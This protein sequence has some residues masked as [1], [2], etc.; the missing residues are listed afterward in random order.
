MIL[1]QAIAWIFD[2]A[3]WVTTA[4][5]T[6]IPDALGAHLAL[7]AWS[8]LFAAIIAL[9][10]GLYIGHSGRGR[11]FAIVAS[12]VARALPTLGLLSILLLAIP[13]VAGIPSGYLPDIIVFALLAIPPILAGAYAGLEAVDPQT[14]DAARAVGMTELQ[15]LFKV[16]IPLGAALIV[17]GLRS[18]TLQIIATVT[19]A[20]LFLQTSLGT[21]I[22]DGLAQ[23][24]YVKMAAGAILVAALALIIDGILAL[25]QRFVSPRGVSRDETKQKRTTARGRLAA[26]TPGTPLE[27]GN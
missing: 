25:V 2:P 7:S 20:S 11:T 10:L 27:E 5:G 17:G 18:G 3:H 1:L 16:E 4:E 14:V 9:P 24:D 12:N 22:S 21:F 13:D 26:A 23:A 19:I 15:V 8:L 6:G